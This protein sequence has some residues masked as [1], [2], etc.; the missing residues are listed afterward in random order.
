MKGVAG[1][2]DTKKISYL[3]LKEIYGICETKNL[4]NDQIN[5]YKMKER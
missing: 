5:E 4:T 2:M 3:V 1:G